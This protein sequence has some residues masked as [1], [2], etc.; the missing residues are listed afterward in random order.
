MGER[1]GRIG[2]IRTD[3]IV[4]FDLKPSEKGSDKP[5]EKTDKTSEK[6]SEKTDKTSEK[7]D[8]TSEKILDLMKLKP[9]ITI[10]EL[11]E[12]TSVSARVVETHLQ[13]LKQN[14]K[15]IRKGG[16]KMGEWEVI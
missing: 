1:M 4:E 2:R 9:K 5:S 3:F 7:T 15:I 6:A 13:N 10:K 8:K 14:H 11:A 12:L 16:R